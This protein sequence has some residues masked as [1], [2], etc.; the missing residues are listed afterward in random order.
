MRTNPSIH[1]FFSNCIIEYPLSVLNRVVCPVAVVSQWAAEIEKMA[2]GLTV[3]EHHGAGRTTDPAR[4][5]RAHVVVTSYS[6]L[7]S[8]H[9]AFIPDA[10][11]EGKGKG[12]TKKKGSS[13]SDDGDEVDEIDSD[14]SSNFGRTL[15][16]K[17]SAPARKTQVKDALFRVKWWRIVL[18]KFIMRND[19]CGETK[20][21]FD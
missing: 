9:G 21:F 5:R 12:K 10:K 17:K 4:L 2:I 20:L 13:D 11:D 1:R 15:T 18:G 7:S 19:C 16:K 3:I 6:I 8:E 14:S